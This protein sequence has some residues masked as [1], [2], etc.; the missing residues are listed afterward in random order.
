MKTKML[1]L[2]MTALPFS[3]CKQRTLQESNTASVPVLD[4][5]R[6]NSSVL[7]LHL[8]ETNVLAG[9]DCGTSFDQNTDVTKCKKVGEIPYDR[10]LTQI[11]EN[12]AKNIR[13]L[14]TR[15]TDFIA[16]VQELE[17]NQTLSSEVL[18]YVKEHE[19][20][21]TSQVREAVAILES[22]ESNLQSIEPELRKPSPSWV[23]PYEQDA[24]GKGYYRVV[25]N[26]TQ[27]QKFVRNYFDRL[28]IPNNFETMQ[29]SDI[30][31]TRFPASFRMIKS[32]NPLHFKQAPLSEN[33]QKSGQI[34]NYYALQYTAIENGKQVGQKMTTKA[35]NL[36]KEY[37]KLW[38]Q[39]FS[40]ELKS[41]PIR[42]SIMGMMLNG[43]L[44]EASDFDGSHCI[45]QVMLTGD[46]SRQWLKTP[47]DHISL[48]PEQTILTNFRYSGSQLDFEILNPFVFNSVSSKLIPFERMNATGLDGN[49]RLKGSMTCNMVEKKS[50]T[51]K[52]VYTLGL[53]SVRDIQKILGSHF[54][55]MTN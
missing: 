27:L 48:M 2:L 22:V 41:E 20:K 35:D 18:Q 19:S 29:L 8:N 36:V 14:R 1:F 53:L 51:G 42:N 50:Q 30:E 52:T 31:S 5:A 46:E 10:A 40:G 54:D 7:F 44:Q 38:S 6:T 34:A 15:H 21:S 33:P 39:M 24:E 16:A 45:M 47:N 28:I 32:S 43:L 55:M 23:G 26:E 37:S 9:Y 17:T 11:R 25:K 12:I 13:A 49:D 3:S 4:G